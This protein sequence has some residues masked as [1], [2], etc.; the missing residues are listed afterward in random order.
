MCL[1]LRLDVELSD[2]LFKARPLLVWRGEPLHSA[3]GVLIAPK[4][5]AEPVEPIDVKRHVVRNHKLRSSEPLG[6]RIASIIG[7]YPV[8]I[9]HQLCNAG[10]LGDEVAHWR[11]RLDERGP[12]GNFAIAFIGDEADFNHGNVGLFAPDTGRLKVNR[13]PTLW[14]ST[15]EPV[16]RLWKDHAA[17]MR[18]RR[19]YVCMSGFRTPHAL[20]RLARGRAAEIL[21]LVGAGA[22]LGCDLLDPT[23]DARIYAASEHAI[24]KASW[25]FHTGLAAL[26]LVVILLFV[27][28]RERSADGALKNAYRGVLR[29]LVIGAIGVIG[30][31]VFPTDPGW[32]VVSVTGRLHP[33]FALIAGGSL[34][35]VGSRL[36]RPRRLLLHIALF[37]GAGFVGG[38]VG[39]GA[40]FAERFALA[41]VGLLLYLGAYRSR[42]AGSASN[43]R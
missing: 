39:G 23:L 16:A 37:Y 5:N 32:T 24:G 13:H 3:E 31:V 18:L 22:I 17:I 7:I 10:Q 34:L 29:G 1:P 43:E 33:I 20:L 2:H 30:V 36:T 6:E 40:G 4:L 25:L 9:H 15:T 19:Y 11:S 28:L 41:V 26:F 8:R 21:V 42:V 27:R 35:Y 38:F 14:E 12:G